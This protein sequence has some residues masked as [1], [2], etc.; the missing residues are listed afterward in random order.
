MGWALAVV[1]PCSWRSNSSDIFR[2]DW[3]RNKGYANGTP[4]ST[5]HYVQGSL[6]LANLVALVLVVK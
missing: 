1:Y 5:A 6:R 3:S 2:F 4:R